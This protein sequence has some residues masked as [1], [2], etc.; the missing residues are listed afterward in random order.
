MITKESMSM[1]QAFYERGSCLSGASLIIKE[2]IIQNKTID[3]VYLNTSVDG[4]FDYCLLNLNSITNYR[5]S[6]PAEIASI[7]DELN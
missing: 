7:S 2:G 5:K 1:L 6:W 3:V 4:F